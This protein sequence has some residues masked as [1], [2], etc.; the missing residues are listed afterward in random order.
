MPRPAKG[1][2][3][4]KAWGEKMKKAR[5]T[6]KQMKGGMIETHT[7]PDGTVMTGKK[8][9]SLSKIITTDKKPRDG[10]MKPMTKKKAVKLLAK[11]LSTNIKKNGPIIV[12]S[13]KKFLDEKNIKGGNNGTLGMIHGDFGL[14]DGLNP[15]IYAAIGLVG[16]TVIIELIGYIADLVDME[17]VF[18]A[19]M[20]EDNINQ[21]LDGAMPSINNRVGQ[22]QGGSIEYNET[23]LS[24]VLGVFGFAGLI[25]VAT[26]VR[27]RMNQQGRVVPAQ[28]QQILEQGGDT[29]SET[30]TNVSQTEVRDVEAV[31]GMIGGRDF[32]QIRQMLDNLQAKY[33]ELLNEDGMESEE[34]DDIQQNIDNLEVLWEQL[35]LSPQLTREEINNIIA[36]YSEISRTL[37]R[38]ERSRR[39]NI[40]EGGKIKNPFKSVS[41]AF[42][43]KK[44]NETFGKIGT[45]VNPINYAMK[46]KRVT[47]LM[48]QSG[49]LTDKYLLPAAVSAGLPLY[50]G[51]AGTAG[52]MLGGPVGALAATRAADTLWQEA[53]VKKG[54]DPRER[55]K[56]KVLGAISEKVGQAGASQYKAGMSGKGYFLSPG[57]TVAQPTNKRV[58]K[59]LGKGY[60]LSPGMTV[61]QPTNKRN[62]GR[63]LQ[64]PGMSDTQP[65][66]KMTEGRYLQGP[67]V[68]KKDL[69]RI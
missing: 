46:D 14:H 5:E 68:N 13:M 62:K 65:T 8:H 27:D 7:H 63:H 21:I 41:K 25:A 42:S 61:A 12:R 23:L 38:Y 69:K 55:Q 40:V 31:G 56:S 10:M 59:V 43:P 28:I 29:D 66:N 44:I 45:A 9:T 57:T 18:P 2:E 50:Y 53:V 54:Y 4:A 1:S 37:D 60:F 11:A 49:Q 26:H 48:R 15:I 39:M 6:K 20:I 32:P 52:M 64:G 67:K 58:G 16:G 35:I 33:D 51:A 36:N 17:D 3:E 22:I 30:D 34:L 19:E 47:N 24:A